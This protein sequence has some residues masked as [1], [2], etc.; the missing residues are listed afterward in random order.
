[1]NGNRTNNNFIPSFTEK[2][3]TY[4]SKITVVSHMSNMLYQGKLQKN[5][6]T[7][8][9]QK[10]VSTKIENHKAKI[11]KTIVNNN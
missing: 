11:V 6:H 5:V 1:M 2:P 4:A 8:H 10:L 7:G 9:A 3:Y